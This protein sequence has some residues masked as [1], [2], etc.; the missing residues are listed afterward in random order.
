MG[1]APTNRKRTTVPAAEAKP[2]R[3]SIVEK[4][5]ERE[6]K[7]NITSIENFNRLPSQ[8]REKEKEKSFRSGSRVKGGSR[9]R[10]EAVEDIVIKDERR[11]FV[12]E[13]MD[14]ERKEHLQGY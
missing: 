13:V 5:N 6:E 12:V 9:N 4:A 14:F 2:S 8:H 3:S 7:E 11:G 1:C 10:I